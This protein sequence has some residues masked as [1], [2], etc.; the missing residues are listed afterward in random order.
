MEE[1]SKTAADTKAANTEHK[2]NWEKVIFSVLKKQ[3]DRKLAVKKLRKK[4][5]ACGCW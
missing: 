3:E 2:F 5:Y 1:T 4:V